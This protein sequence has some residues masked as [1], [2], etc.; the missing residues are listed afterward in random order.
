MALRKYLK[1]AGWKEETATFESLAG[2]LTV[3][4][5]QCM[6][7]IVYAD[8]G[9]EPAEISVMAIGAQLVPQKPVKKPK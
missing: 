3:I 5:D 9:V 1:E 6:L 8:V 2:N 7:T 4:K